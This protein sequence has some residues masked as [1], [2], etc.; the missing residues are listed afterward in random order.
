MGAESISGSVRNKSK[1]LVGDNKAEGRI[2]EDLFEGQG[3]RAGIL[4]IKNHLTARFLPRGR[5]KVVK[6]ELD[7]KIVSPEGRVAFIDTKSWGRERIG[8]N[9]FD[10]AQMKRAVLYNEW[11]VPAGFV[12]W[13][14][15][16]NIITFLA[17]QD[18]A[19]RGPGNS[20]APEDGVYLGRFENFALEPIF[21]FQ[22]MPMHLK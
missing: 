1:R 8:F 11:N 10:E 6:S 18:I 12:C 15:T 20:F 9:E 17:G 5:V 14:R 7:W 19:W 22:R 13:W 2:F 16:Q 21:A 3:Q 4:V